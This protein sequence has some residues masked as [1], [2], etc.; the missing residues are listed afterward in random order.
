[1]KINKTLAVISLY[2]LAFT[3]VPSF[4]S[5]AEAGD[6]LGYSNFT[7]ST[8]AIPSGGFTSSVS[9]T[10]IAQILNSTPLTYDTTLSFQISEIDPISNDV[11]NKSFTFV[12]QPSGNL[13]SNI[14]VTTFLSSN[15]LNQAND[16][17][18]G[19]LLEFVPGGFTVL[20]VPRAVPEPLTILGAATAT[21]FGAF[22][23]RKRKLSESSE[24]DNTKTS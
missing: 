11:F 10:F 20:Q 17:L 2:S 23:K 13:P 4:F 6:F 8:V 3:C 9:F 5:K 1:M 19:G 22:F 15:E 21:G 14:T 7:P 18:E 24:K 16:Y 12:E